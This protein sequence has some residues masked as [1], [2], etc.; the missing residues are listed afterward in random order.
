[1]RVFDK[2]KI[3]ELFEYDLAKGYLK[4][5]V[6]T[7]YIPEVV[8]VEEVFHYEVV[9][10]FPNGG[11]TLKKVVDKPAIKGVPAHEEVE[12]ILIYIPYTEFELLKIKAQTRILELKELLEETDYKAIKYAEG[13]I[14]Y[15]EY[16][17][18]KNQRQAWRNEING[19]EIYL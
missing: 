12:D 17:P 6:L 8:G 3:N 14:S 2:N 16:E 11:R 9:K 10:E 15:E 19:L 18:I 1:M 7:K 13:L 4:E 5:D